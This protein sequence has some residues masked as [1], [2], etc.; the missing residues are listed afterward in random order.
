M[1]LFNLLVDLDTATKKSEYDST[2]LSRFEV[3]CAPSS[4]FAICTRRNASSV[5]SE[6]D[7]RERDM[8]QSKTITGGARF[9]RS[10][11]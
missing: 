6:M 8:N 4:K 9:D 1:L 10:G 5:E 11:C 2:S 3:K 7:E